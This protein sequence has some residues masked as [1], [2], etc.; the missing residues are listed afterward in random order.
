M[1]YGRITAMLMGFSVALLGLITVTGYALSRA[2]WYA[3]GGA[4]MPGMGLNTGIALLMMGTGMII[5]ATEK[6]P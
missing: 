6:R 3:W 5:M 2:S 1:S 4:H